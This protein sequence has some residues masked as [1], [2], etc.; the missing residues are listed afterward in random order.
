MD[1]LA[2][3]LVDLGVDLSPFYR[4]LDTAVTTAQQQGA[5]AGNAFSVGFVGNL[6]TVLGGY[7]QLKS[8]LRE[9]FSALSEIT[10][11]GTAAFFQTQEVGFTTL[12]RDGEKA[13]KLLAE[14][15][16]LGARTPFDTGQ[17]TK[18]ARQ[19]LAAGFEADGLVR[20]VGIVSDAV[21]GMGLGTEAV[22]R[23]TRVLA[24]IRAGGLKGNNPLQL[25]ELGLNIADLA[26]ISAGRKISNQ[27]EAKAFFNSKGPEKAAEALFDALD[28]RFNGAA[29]RLGGTTL[30]GIVQNLGEAVQN[31]LLPSGRAL[32]PVV[33]GIAIGMRFLVDGFGKLNEATGGA[34]GIAALT[35]IAAVGI[36]RFSAG[37]TQSILVT[38]LL[39]SALQQYTGAATGAAVAA[40]TSAAASAGGGIASMVGAG[41]PALLKAA[42]PMLA[43]TA[44]SV[45][46]N[47][48]GGALEKNG[49]KLVSG[50]GTFLQGA[51]TG[52]GIGGAIGSVIPGIGTVVGALVGGAIGGIGSL[53]GRIISETKKSDT[54]ASTKT[55][56]ATAKT[57]EA[58]ADAAASLKEMKNQIL[59]GGERSRRV[60]SAIEFEYSLYGAVRG[61]G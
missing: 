26:S 3:L 30:V 52:A 46:G 36:V 2:S 33:Q 35:G 18:F 32:L 53:I 9:T 47:L 28:K 61:I 38:N 39:T 45:I 41:L 12:L 16:D 8:V 58:T 7:G 54:D 13:K 27:D 31:S 10:G 20:R 50:A 21:A 4:G 24:Q 55:A 43:V 6:Q 48:A 60:V 15:R 34:A 29:E 51:G 42:I 22:G 44:L 1:E 23:L 25:Q 5:K 19:L 40:R 57:A 56:Q 17:L 11:V 14:L 37:V 59:G 49:N